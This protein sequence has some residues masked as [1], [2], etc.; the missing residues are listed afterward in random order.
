M[1]LQYFINSLAVGSVI[2]LTALGF[3]LIY[4]TT[5]VFHIAHGAIFTIGAFTV[6]A[7]ANYFGAP[8]YV[9]LSFAVLFSGLIGV[10]IE[11]LCYYPLFK[12]RASETVL[13]LVS[14]SLYSVLVNLLA[15]IFGNE[16]QILQSGQSKTFSLGAANATLPQILQILTAITVGAI[17][18][19]VL[20]N[21]QIGKIL[22]AVRDDSNLAATHGVNFSVVRR[23]SFF[24]GSALAGL[25]GALTA[26]DVGFD[27]QIGFGAFLAGSIAV[28]V[29]GA[30]N[31]TGAIVGAFLL[32]ILQSVVTYL[33][34]AHWESAATLFVLAVFLLFKPEGLLATARRAEEV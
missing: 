31:F 25:A 3:A 32:A 1:I 10:L 34:G 21:T 29:G 33:A 12:S 30:G 11:W 16:A 23:S 7:L 19:F 14:L 18:F 9:A 22:K 17:F 20:N 27:P 6:F 8:W 5:K 13:L 4:N 28:I 24:V 26:F 15:I 2:Y